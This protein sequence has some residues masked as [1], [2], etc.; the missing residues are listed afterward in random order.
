MGFS[1]GGGLSPGCGAGKAGMGYEPRNT[2]RPVFEVWN[3]I[4]SSIASAISV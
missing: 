2:I 4:D 1:S 3:A